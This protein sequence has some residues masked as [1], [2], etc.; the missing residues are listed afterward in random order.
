MFRVWGVKRSIKQ[1]RHEITMLTVEVPPDDIPI[2]TYDAEKA[3][4][5]LAGLK[6]IRALEESIRA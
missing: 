3:E 6:R 2:H 4:E 5:I 1:I